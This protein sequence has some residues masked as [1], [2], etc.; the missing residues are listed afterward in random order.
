[1]FL[2][3]MGSVNILSVCWFVYVNNKKKTI[4]LLIT[5]KLNGLKRETFS[6]KKINSKSNFA[7]KNFGGHN[8]TALFF[9][10]GE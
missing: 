9:Q 1:M 8:V 5:K 4:K 3:Q 2:I 6:L 10:R 7:S